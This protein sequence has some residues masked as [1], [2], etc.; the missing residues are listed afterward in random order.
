MPREELN[1][2]RCLLLIEQDGYLRFFLEEMLRFPPLSTVS[3]SDTAAAC[4]V[5]GERDFDTVM[6]NLPA[7][8]QAQISPVNLLVECNHQVPLIVVSDRSDVDFAVEVLRSG[9][10]DYLTRPFNNIARVDSAILKSFMKHDQVRQAA[11][12]NKEESHPYGLRGN[13]K[14]L[15]ELIGVINQIAPL[16]VS[17]LITGESGTG[18]ELVARAIHGRSSRSG[19][20]FFA[21]NCGALPEG[22]VESI[23]FGHEKGAFTGAVSATRG[24][25]EKSQGGTL[26]LDEVG[27]LSPK[28]QVALLRFLEEREFV[29]VGGTKTISS[30]ARV[31]A[32]TNR[33]LEKEVAEN[34]FRADVHF[35]L[36]VVHL[37]VP[38]LRERRED[39]LNLAQYFIRRFCVSNA[40]PERT[41][42]ASAAR[43]LERY[44]WPGNVRELENLMEGLM[45]ILPTA[46]SIISDNDILAYSDKIKHS[47]ATRESKSSDRIPEFEFTEMR[48]QE[49]LEQFE[50]VYLKGLLKAH[51]GNVTRAA[52]AAGIHP[53][54]FHRKL[55][56]F[57]IVR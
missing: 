56:K 18:K 42:S 41:L 1:D 50:V 12:L 26:F 32:S 23:L 51:G 14:P 45:A 48:H 47:T 30:D 13:S 33:D 40:V 8:T 24:F 46:H 34:R 37:K 20:P 17:V 9:A 3:V 38:P 53:V 19:G 22:L 55:R 5:L 28:G 15:R 31:I 21:V 6:M 57:R 16:N 52:K 49:A 54:T 43:L 7:F 10:F 36:N 39:I 25:L 35:R 29:R 27:E 2:P 11:L 4:R 44:E